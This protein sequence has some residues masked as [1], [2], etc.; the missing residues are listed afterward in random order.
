VSFN[1]GGRRV[2]PNRNTDDKHG[3]CN[4]LS[5]GDRLAITGTINGNS[6]TATDIE[7]KGSKGD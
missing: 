2:V 5:N 4:D 3:K 7:L 1:A 6:V